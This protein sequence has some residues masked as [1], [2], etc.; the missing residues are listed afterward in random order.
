MRQFDDASRI[1][2]GH[3]PV[4]HWSVVLRALREASGVN[5]EGWAARLGYGR[6]TIQR[7]EYGDLVPNSTAKEALITLRACKNISSGF[8]GTSG[9]VG[10]WR[11]VQASTRR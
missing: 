1:T 9:Q 8:L 10:G 7:W 4:P 5:Q 3:R 2:E 11:R 6:R